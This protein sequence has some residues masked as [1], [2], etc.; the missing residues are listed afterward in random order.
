M[1]GLHSAAPGCPKPSREGRATHTSS[2]AA[3]EGGPI[4]SCLLSGTQP[5]V[6]P[7]CFLTA[8]TF[9]AQGQNENM[10]AEN[11]QPP[12]M[13]G[14]RKTLRLPGECMCFQK[15]SPDP[16]VFPHH[17][18]FP[19]TPYHHCCSSHPPPTTEAQGSRLNTSQQPSLHP[20]QGGQQTTYH[21]SL[22]SSPC[23]A[24]TA[25]TTPLTYGV[26]MKPQLLPHQPKT[27]LLAPQLLEHM[28]CSSL[29]QAPH[30][31]HQAPA[32]L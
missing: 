24:H 27:S 10:P 23:S 9:S 32:G 25:S 8:L 29:S 18:H 5:V 6:E 31:L 11:R 12:V 2:H 4:Y 16:S 7:S 13:G 3:A 21:T 17:L 14:K 28:H 30:C 15:K 26:C 22:Q 1:H 19:Q 20:W